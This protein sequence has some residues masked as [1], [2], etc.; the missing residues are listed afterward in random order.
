MA[1]VYAR[2]PDMLLNS[3]PE[4]LT[5]A[6]RRYQRPSTC[7]R[8]KSRMSPRS[9]GDCL[10]RAVAYDLIT[11]CWPHNWLWT[12]DLAGSGRLCARPT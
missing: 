12:I 4:L 6:G 11:I 5:C 7:G 1:I 3:W 8:I 2:Q 9:Q 10:K